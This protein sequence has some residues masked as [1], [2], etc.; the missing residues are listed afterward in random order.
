MQRRKTDVMNI[1][2]IGIDHSIAAVE[3]R[4]IFSFTKSKQKDAMYVFCRM[5]GVNGC[6]ILSTCNRMEIY[7]STEENVSVDLYEEI[8]RF[9]QV[10]AERYREY[11]T[12]RRGKD[13]AEH[14]FYLASG[15]E[16]RIVGEDQIL[17]QVKEALNYAR[18]CDAADKVLE[19]LFRMAVT[20]GKKVKTDIH[21]SRGNSSAIHEA[22]AQLRQRGMD[23]VGKKCM[24]IG[25]GEMGRLTALALKD[26]GADVTVT[27]R[28]YRSGKVLIPDGCSRIHYGERYDFIPGC[29]FIVSA[30]ASPNLTLVKEEIEKIDISDKKVFLDLAVPRDIDPAIAEIPNLEVYDIDAF[31][32]DKQSAELREQLQAAAKLVQTSLEEFVSWYECRNFVPMIQKISQAAAKD[33]SWRMGKTFGQMELPP[34]ER[35]NLENSIEAV[36]AKVFNKL[37]F[38]LR[39]DVSTDML[40]ECLE[41]FANA[42]PEVYS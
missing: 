21:F 3:Y 22:L 25:N 4:E 37:L 10:P 39:D 24:V 8:C 35:Q 9:K 11:F 33:V 18:E 2:M 31:Q 12:A 5:S 23:F 1:Q 42:Y 41:A 20:T 28:Q 16:S 40:R 29:S 7:I 14:L 26:A 36:S 19:V 38:E 17:M 15:M 34:K 6:V 30:T 32:I 13:A 27:V